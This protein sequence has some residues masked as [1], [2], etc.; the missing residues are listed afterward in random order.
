MEH[1]T[2]Y[3]EAALE[4]VERLEGGWEILFDDCRLFWV[5][6]GEHGVEPEVGDVARFYGDGFYNR[7]LAINGRTVFY[8]SPAEHAAYQA[9]EAERLRVQMAEQKSHDRPIDQAFRETWAADPS[10]ESMEEL[11]EVMASLVDRE[12]TYETSALAVALAAVAAFNYAAHK[13]GITGFQAGYAELE[14]LRRSRRIEGPFGIVDGSHLLYPQ[15]DLLAEVREWIEKWRPSLAPKARELLA[16]A[17]GYVH[18]DV[19]AH[20]ERMAALTDQPTQRA[21]EDEHA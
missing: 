10:P 6:D 12:H 18:P 8:R 14:F 5:Q 9:I 4:R 7:G 13:L 2:E 21:T 16:N 3:F 19:R 1:D 17:T 20:W 15:Y 11:N